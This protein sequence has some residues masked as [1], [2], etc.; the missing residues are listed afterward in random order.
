MGHVAMAVIIRAII[1]YVEEESKRDLVT[2]LSK[3][4]SLIQA[5]PD[6]DQSTVAAHLHS[7][8]MQFLQLKMPT[9]LT[10]GKPINKKAPKEDKPW[11]WSFMPESTSI[12]VEFRLWLVEFVAQAMED[13]KLL[14]IR[15]GRPRRGG[16][17]EEIAKHVKDWKKGPSTADM[18]DDDDSKG[19][20]RT[21]GHRKG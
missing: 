20:K 3:A 21:R 19:G 13:S 6:K 2:F 9:L 8:L 17:P 11:G 4:P 16:L 7:R 1:K 12:G 5:N 10:S 18:S 15:R 14:T